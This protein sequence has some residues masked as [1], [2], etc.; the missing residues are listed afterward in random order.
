MGVMDKIEDLVFQ[1]RSLSSVEI[2]K[3]KCVV[4]KMRCVIEK[5]TDTECCLLSASG[6]RYRIFGDR[7]KIKEYGDTYV[8]VSTLMLRNFAIE[9][10]QDE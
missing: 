1:S 4:V 9:G 8:K 10:D 2:L 6:V 7:L 3:D 5:L